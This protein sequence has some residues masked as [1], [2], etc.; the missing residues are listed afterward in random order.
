MSLVRI[1]NSDELW[2]RLPELMDLIERDNALYRM[3]LDMLN[4]PRLNH[5]LQ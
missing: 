5:A 1:H 2:G 3:L 4:D